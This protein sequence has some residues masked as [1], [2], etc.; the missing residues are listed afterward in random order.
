MKKNLI[1]K[2]MAFVR[3]ECNYPAHIIRM[4][5]F[6]D[7]QFCRR[8]SRPGPWAAKTAAILLRFYGV[9]FMGEAFKILSPDKRVFIPDIMASCSLAESCQR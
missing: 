7:I 6:Q 8:Q 9:H 1:D 4:L 2:M 5:I 3:E